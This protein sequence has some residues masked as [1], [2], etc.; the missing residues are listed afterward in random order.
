[1]GL[2]GFRKR[3]KEIRMRDLIRRAGSL[4]N[5]PPVRSLD[6]FIR[7]TEFA[8]DLSHSGRRTCAVR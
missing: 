5:M 3:Q 1:M 8:L 7:L 4:K 2:E 6:M